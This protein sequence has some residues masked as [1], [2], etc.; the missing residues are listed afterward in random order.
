MC[1]CHRG[2]TNIRIGKGIPGGGIPGGGTPY[3]P[4]GGGMFGGGLI[5]GGG[6]PAAIGG[7][8]TAAFCGGGAAGA[9]DAVAADGGALPLVCASTESI[10]TRDGRRKEECPEN[11]YSGSRA[12]F[13][14]NG[15]RW[16]TTTRRRLFSC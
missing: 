13:A 11:A 16:T 10:F 7:I 1:C 3:M 14:G 2:A 9:A 15:E 8:G 4:G 6:A 12:S 5:I